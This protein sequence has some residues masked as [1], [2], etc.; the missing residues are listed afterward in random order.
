MSTDYIKVIWITCPLRKTFGNSIFVQINNQREKVDAFRRWKR[1]AE[2]EVAL[3]LERGPLDRLDMVHELGFEG[4][5]NRMN[6][7]GK[8]RLKEDA[9]FNR[10]K[11]NHFVRN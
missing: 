6:S 9:C 2:E 8:A 4:N 1:A 10:L 3:L 5:M 7:S 11:D